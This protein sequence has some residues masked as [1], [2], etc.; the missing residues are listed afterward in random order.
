MSATLKVTPNNNW[1]E[2]YLSAFNSTSLFHIFSTIIY[3]PYHVLLYLCFKIEYFK[4]QTLTFF[5]IKGSENLY[6]SVQSPETYFSLEHFHKRSVHLAQLSISLYLQ[7]WSF[8]SRSTKLI[9]KIKTHLE[10]DFLPNIN[11]MFN[12]FLNIDFNKTEYFFFF[13]KNKQSRY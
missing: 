6:R 2:R 4:G 7:I 9:L 10:S 5:N 13:G 12:R 11:Y 1:I 8:C 3:F